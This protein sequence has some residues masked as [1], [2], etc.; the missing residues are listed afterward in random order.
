MYSQTGAQNELFTEMIK[1]WIFSLNAHTPFASL[2]IHLPGLSLTPHLY[3]WEIGT[4]VIQHVSIS[5][6]NLYGTFLIACS[7]QLWF[8]SRHRQLPNSTPDTHSHSRF[9]TTAVVFGNEFCVFW[10]KSWTLFR[11]VHTNM[12]KSGS[13]DSYSIWHNSD[14]IYIPYPL[15]D[16]LYSHYKEKKFTGIKKK[17]C[18]LRNVEFIWVAA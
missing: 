16:L 1:S 10:W 9:E 3:S 5:V 8:R 12:Q 13:V 18:F 14:D 4:E 15:N 11:Q 7:H 6:C 17:T 2:H